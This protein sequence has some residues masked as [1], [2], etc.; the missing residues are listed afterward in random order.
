MTGGRAGPSR[1]RRTRAALRSGLPGAGAILA[2]VVAWQLVTWAFAIPKFLLPSPQDV[3]ESI[4]RLGGVWAAHIWN[5][6]KA[7]LL[8]FALAVVLGLGLAIAI[9]QSRFLSRVLTPVLVI[10]QIIPKIAFAPLFLI[11]LGTG[12]PPIVMIVFLVAFFPMVVNSA[13]GMADVEPELI[14]LTRVLHLSWWRVLWTIRLPNA[15]PHIFSGMR[16]ASTLAVIGAI[17]GEFVGS[18][19][20]LGYLILI[21]NNQLDTP[22]A[23]ASIIII[24]VF[25]L[26]LYGVIAAIE[27]RSM[28][29]RVRAPAAQGLSI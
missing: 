4:P 19:V 14:D 17:I 11:W 22:L 25:G 13:V 27:S 21:A 7:T 8:G 18:N 1:F 5:T 28:P 16:V 6:V 2:V 26:L 9:V 29:W 24:S 20:G 12:L 23:F 3:A 10:L 15:L